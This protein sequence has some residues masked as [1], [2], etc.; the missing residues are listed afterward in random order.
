MVARLA[1]QRTG[2]SMAENNAKK[3]IQLDKRTIDRQLARG[4]VT[5]SE[6]EAYLANLP[7]L[8]EQ[9]DNIASIVYGERPEEG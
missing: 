3:L 7:D 8:A 6:Y 1:F 4:A 5:P 2:A 9:A